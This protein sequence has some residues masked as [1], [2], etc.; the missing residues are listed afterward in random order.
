MISNFSINKNSKNNNNQEQ[1]PNTKIKIVYYDD[2]FVGV[3][4]I[5][6][7]D[8]YKQKTYT[9]DDLKRDSC[10][11]WSIDYKI[12][13]QYMIIDDQKFVFSLRLLVYDIFLKRTLKCKD[14]T[15]L[16]LQFE[17]VE[18]SKIFY[19]GKSGIENKR[20]QFRKYEIVDLNQQSE[21]ANENSIQTQFIKK[22]STF[23][24]DIE[25]YVYFIYRIEA[26]QSLF[27]KEEKEGVIKENEN[28]DTNS[29]QNNK[30]EIKESENSSQIEDIK[31]T[32]E[33]E[34]EERQKKI[35]EQNNKKQEPKKSK[36]QPPLYISLYDLH[37]FRLFKCYSI[38]CSFLLIIFSILN[39]FYIGEI[40]ITE[41][42]QIKEALLKALFNPLLSTCFKNGDKFE[43]Q[44]LDEI[45]IKKNELLMWLDI[46]F[47]NF[48]FIT[49]AQLEDEDN[50]N[51]ETKEYFLNT[52]Q[53]Y[54]ELVGIIRFAYQKMNIIYDLKAEYGYIK[55]NILDILRQNYSDFSSNEKYN[56]LTKSLKPL[57]LEYITDRESDKY[58]TIYA[59]LYDSNNI[60]NFENNSTICGSN[61]IEHCISENNDGYM[62][63]DYLNEEPITNFNGKFG[64]YSGNGYY[65]SYN[66]DDISTEAFKFSMMYLKRSIFLEEGLR[67]FTIDLNVVHSYLRYIAHVSIFFEFSNVG[68]IRTKIDIDVRH[69]LNITY[70]FFIF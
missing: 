63:Y 70:I 62:N 49:E 55:P 13:N 68:N 7:T 25:E 9:F 38:F 59:P 6:F 16:R 51:P 12:R 15:A 46:V 3:F 60:I 53:T 14:K 2:D 5:D 50:Y 56:T 44:H 8:K 65:L 52:N 41:R 36:L 29:N 17:L 19:S 32:E 61:F 39:A 54:Y 28:N 45:I 24:S 57:H 22:S 35:K 31:N 21:L 10:N 47:S 40:S 11:Y 33:R 42:V 30:E 58:N 48:A 18:K 4:E 66:V 67:L 23:V 26:V 37:K 34:E 27:S 20:N 1:E 64:D 69:S 43:K